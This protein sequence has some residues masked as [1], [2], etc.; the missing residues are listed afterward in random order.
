MKVTE[1]SVSTPVESVPMM[2]TTMTGQDHR[3]HIEEIKDPS[4]FYA[5]VARPVSH[6]EFAANPKAIEAAEIEW[7]RLRAVG[8]TGCWDELHPRD[9]A[10]VM[11]EARYSGRTVQF[12]KLMEICV[13]RNS[14]T[15]GQGQYKV[16]V[17]HWGD[18]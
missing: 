15:L 12:G 1:S 3:S 16:R 5:C 4:S 10:E 9:K 13:E 7:G 2:P 17:V 8:K 11:S 18:C 14:D 6:A